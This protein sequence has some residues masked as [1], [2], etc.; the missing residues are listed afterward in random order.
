M[1]FNQKENFKNI[2][3]ETLDIINRGFYIN[4]NRN[5]LIIKDLVDEAVAGTELIVNNINKISID[6]SNMYNA[7]NIFVV[8]SSTIDTII[9]LRETGIEG[10]IIALNFASAKHP[11]G[12]FLNGA[13]AQEESIVRAS[14]LYPCLTKFKRDFYDFHESYKNPL[15]SDLM[16]YSSSVPI[17]RNNKGELLSNPIISS[18]I[19]SPAVN[20][21]VAKSVGIGENV[22][23]ETMKNRIRYIVDLALSKNPQVVVLGAYG[24]G[25]FGNEPSRIAELFKLA[26]QTTKIREN[27]DKTKI[28]F[29]IYG[30]EELIEIFKNKL[31]LL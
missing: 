14:A 3:N 2:A 6:N 5:K 20:A 10:N 28:I 24:C 31:D 4:K 15:Y 23:I 13:N 1:K 26:L 17:F 7:N 29:S 9:N 25:V 19:T 22:I 16:I 27:L 21:K 18:F 12:G 8:Q 11:G 30:N